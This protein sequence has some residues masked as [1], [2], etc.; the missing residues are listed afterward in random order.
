MAECH[1]ITSDIP[2]ALS[3]A[4]RCVGQQLLKGEPRATVED[5]VLD[6][7]RLIVLFSSAQ[8]GLAANLTDRFQS[9]KK[10]VGTKVTN[11]RHR[12]SRRRRRLIGLFP[13]RNLQQEQS[14][15][16][17]AVQSATYK[18]NLMPSTL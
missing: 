16:A 8:V 4:L 2:S 13:W 5:W 12:L 17:I 18:I 11:R 1:A 10:T 14:L 3:A 15:Q 7:N 9:L 6:V